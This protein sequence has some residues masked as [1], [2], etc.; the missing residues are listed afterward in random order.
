VL[1]HQDIQPWNLLAREG[2]SVVLDWE[3]SGMLDLSGELGSAALSL[4]KGPGFDDIQPTIFA[5]VLDGYVAG[6]GG[7][8]PSGPSWFVFMIDG[9]LGHTRWNILR[10][11]AGGEVSTGPDLA[12][13]HESVR[14]GVRGLPDLF[15]RLP[16]LRRSSCDSDPHWT[17]ADARIPVSAG[18]DTG[19]AERNVSRASPGVARSQQTPAAANLLSKCAGCGPLAAPTRARSRSAFDTLRG[20]RPSLET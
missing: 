9:W 20:W 15:G 8:P 13:A 18:R 1:T 17:D 19:G 6:G 16:E 11:L 5:S 7:L 3:L 14:N 12:L 2:R 4:A 10:C